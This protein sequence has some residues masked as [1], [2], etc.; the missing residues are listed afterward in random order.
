MVAP[1]IEG[2]GRRWFFKHLAISTTLAFALA[3]AHERLYV[4]KR[5]AVRD[6]YY[7]DV[8]VKWTRIVD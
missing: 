6:K 7:E 2:T 4:R 1:V 3:E 8:G 5:I